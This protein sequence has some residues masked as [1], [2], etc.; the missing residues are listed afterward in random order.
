MP[1]EMHDTKTLYSFEGMFKGAT[2]YSSPDESFYIKKFQLKDS[3]RLVT[4]TGFL[5]NTAPN[6]PYIVK[7]KW[8]Y[9][10]KYDTWQIKAED[11]EKATETFSEK[12]TIQYLSSDLFSGIGPT[13]AAKIY[14]EFGD[15][16]VSIAENA[17]EKL[18]VIKGI[19]QRKVDIISES[20]KRNKY[21]KQIMAELY[22]K[23]FS[24]NLCQKIY[25][26]YEDKSVAVIK[27]KP[28]SLAYDIS[29]IGFKK[30]DEIAIKYDNIKYHDIERV[31]AAIFFA[32]K[33]KC[34]SEGHTY[35][36]IND[37]VDITKDLLN[38]NKDD[39]VTFQEML[40]ALES[41]CEDK[42][43]VLREG[44]LYL[45]S[46]YKAE[47][48]SV[49]K[50]VD[51]IQA[52]SKTNFSKNDI[53]A[54]IDW[55]EKKNKL[56]LAEEQKRAIVKS[57]SNSFSVVTGYPGTGKSFTIRGI[58]DIFKYLFE[59]KYSEI[60]KV[61][62]L[63]PDPDRP[64]AEND[65]GTGILTRITTLEETCAPTGKAARRIEES[66]GYKSK[67]IHRLLE[68]D[69][70]TRGFKRNEENPLEAG[71]IVVD[72]VS[73]VDI[74]LYSSFINAIQKGKTKVVLVGDPDQLPS[75]GPG[76]V[77]HDLITAENYVPVTRLTAIFRQAETSNIVKN[78]HKI[79]KYEK[80]TTL[81]NSKNDFQMY[82]LS[83]EMAEESIFQFILNK[84]KEEMKNYED[85]QILCPARKESVKVSSTNLNPLISQIANPSHQKGPSIKKGE[86]TVFHVN[87][88]VIQTKNNYKKDVFN[89][90][91]GYIKRIKDGVITIKFANVEANY[92]SAEEFDLAYA[93]TV[94]RSQGSEF[95]C[96]IVPV[97]KSNTFMLNKSLIYTA[98]TRAKKKVILIAHKRTLDMALKKLG[99]K[100]NTSMAEDLQVYYNSGRLPNF[101]EF[102]KEDIKKLAKIDLFGKTDEY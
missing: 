14:E 85:I 36:E 58:I 30:A 96:V 28:Y 76:N 22:T 73:M 27:E 3:H 34:E 31:K 44:H 70:A 47:R 49:Q 100:R 80:G 6:I 98:I 10:Q 45:M 53:L 35:V 2:I 24:F 95:D 33:T 71:L 55:Y 75:V 39:F 61:I 101:V 84:Y 32:I 16:S 86:K 67:T 52:D 99:D 56:T 7:G 60:Y 63:R 50:T 68:V 92:I 65:D 29:G 74:R 43:V 12:D 13:T 88:K 89:G 78:S 54:G 11:F 21:L 81:T 26:E 17:P 66:T 25:N 57:L 38:T 69:G 64:I 79:R 94:H 91:T 77:L 59:Q 1:I 90:D 19:T 18:L 5:K 82:Y 20:F 41:L 15:K 102:T 62:K 72:E 42:R 97:L 46:L 87:D 37:I 93:M 23:G 48:D 9:N 4:V 51:L 83:D 40:T 8:N